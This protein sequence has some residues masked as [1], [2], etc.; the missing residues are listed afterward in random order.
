MSRSA[1]ARSARV[2]V[3]RQCCSWS[4]A[5]PCRNASSERST[6]RIRS[7]TCVR[8]SS[9][10]PST[11]VMYSSLNSAMLGPIGPVNGCVIT[12]SS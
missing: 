2:A 8:S 10:C 4:M 12:R 5:N 3:C 7:G 11:Y 1:P 6:A 9:R